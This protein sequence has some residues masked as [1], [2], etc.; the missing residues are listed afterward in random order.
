M[1]RG[2]REYLRQSVVFDDANARRALPRALWRRARLSPAAFHALI[3]L[4]LTTEARPADGGSTRRRLES[5][6]GSG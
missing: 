2:Y 3:D 6:R 5:A 1:L 4:A